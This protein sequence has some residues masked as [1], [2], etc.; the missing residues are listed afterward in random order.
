MK[1]IFY[2]AF[3][4]HHQCNNKPKLP[5]LKYIYQYRSQKTHAIDCK[6]CNRPLL[7]EP[8]T[9]KGKYVKRQP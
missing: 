6:Y 2:Q 1:L 3:C 4:S 5:T 7:W 8:Y 9:Y